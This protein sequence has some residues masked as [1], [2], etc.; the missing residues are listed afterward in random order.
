M[1][2][3]TNQVIVILALIFFTLTS[4]KVTQ[5]SKISFPKNT[6]K[7]IEQVQQ[8]PLPSLYLGEEDMVKNDGVHIWFERIGNPN[9]PCILLIMGYSASAIA[10]SPDFIRQLVDQGFQVI[11][12]DHRDVGYSTWAQDWNKKKAYDLST[13]ASDGICIL[14]Q[15][16]IQQAHIVGNSMGGMIGQTMA[17][18]YPERVASLTSLATT[19]YLLDP[20]LPAVN[21]K[22]ITKS[23]LNNIKYGVHPKKFKKQVKKRVETVLF[24]QN[25]KQAT[26]TI[27]ERVAKRIF[28]ENKEGRKSNP[29]VG[30]HHR[31]AIKK[32]GSR[33]EHL[34]NVSTPVLVIHGAADRLIPLPHAEKYA[35]VLNDKKMVVIDEMGHIPKA[36]EWQQIG[37]EIIDFLDDKMTADMK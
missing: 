5:T 35:A 24:F 15:L 6:K 37:Q 10:W 11:R 4:C 33:L 20:D 27:I 7:V 25:E 31:T 32:S 14:N 28:F 21:S 22:V 1:N 29:K 34:K 23:V 26:P 30:K 13:M 17:I 18:Q 9:D 16:G 19:G 2:L 36:K 3:K 12:Y 8:T